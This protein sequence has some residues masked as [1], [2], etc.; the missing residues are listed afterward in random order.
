MDAPHLRNMFYSCLVQQH[1]SL[2]ICEL[3][4]ETDLKIYMDNPISLKI[5][6]YKSTERWLKQ[7]K[8]HFKRQEG[9]WDKKVDS[10]EYGYFSWS[11]S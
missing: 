3:D 9:S 11:R 1:N 7:N 8:F 2:H 4:L 5:Y 6:T 10:K